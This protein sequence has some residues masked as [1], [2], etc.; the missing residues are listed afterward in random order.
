MVERKIERKEIWDPSIQEYVKEELPTVTVKQAAR[1]TGAVGQPRLSSYEI[2]S[3]TISGEWHPPKVLRVT[4][5]HV[6]ANKSAYFSVIEGRG[7]IDHL[8]L[9][10]AGDFA[11]L[12]QP[13]APVYTAKG[14]FV[15]RQGSLAAAGGT[16]IVGWEGLMPRYG[17]ESIPGTS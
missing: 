3:G 9:E 11:Q 7:T 2:R 10:A 5:F 15:V 17:S 6:A 12:G 1:L 4:R 14:K 13:G 8:Y 16:Y